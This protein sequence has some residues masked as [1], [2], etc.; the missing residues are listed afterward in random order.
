VPSNQVCC[1]KEREG[2]GREGG[3][4]RGEKESLLMPRWMRLELKN[5]RSNETV[6]E[7]ILKAKL[8]VLN[9]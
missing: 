7:I 8:L 2:E 6:D 4:E 5:N 1:R 3:E 9:K